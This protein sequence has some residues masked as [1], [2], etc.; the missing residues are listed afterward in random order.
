MDGGSKHCTGG[1]NQNYPQ[2]KE[3]QKGKMVIWG[4]FTNSQE[5]KRSESQKR[6]GKIYPSPPLALFIVMLSR[7]HLT[8]HSRMS[9]SRW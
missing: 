2:E 5:K 7:A 9:G 3:I 1:G 8:S 6:K 4:G